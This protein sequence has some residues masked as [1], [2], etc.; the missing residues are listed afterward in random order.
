MPILLYA[1]TNSEAYLGLKSKDKIK[2]TFLYHQRAIGQNV[3]LLFHVLDLCGDV[4]VVD[5]EVAQ[6]VF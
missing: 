3:E 2:V 6:L 1:L 4:L 5:W